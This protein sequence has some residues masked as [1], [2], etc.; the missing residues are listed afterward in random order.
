MSE[1]RRAGLAANLTWVCDEDWALSR[2]PGIWRACPLDAPHSL[3]GAV[4]LKR[5]SA[6]YPI[7]RVL[8]GTAILTRKPWEHPE[9]PSCHPGT[10]SP[11]ALSPP[12]ALCALWTCRTG[13]S[14]VPRTRNTNSWAPQ[15]S[16]RG[17][18]RLTRRPGVLY[19]LQ[20]TELGEAGHGAGGAEARALNR[21]RCSPRWTGD[22][23][24]HAHG[25]GVAG[26][27]CDGQAHSGSPGKGGWQEAAAWDHC[28]LPSCTTAPF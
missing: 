27:R 24:S 5:R 23:V 20:S 18:C 4:P 8:K 16:C 7:W 3:G 10:R 17:R 19:N 11:R 9:K 1:S 21:H 25:V 26:C 6:F 2:G 12:L 14:W 28:P 13:V 15:T 22:Q